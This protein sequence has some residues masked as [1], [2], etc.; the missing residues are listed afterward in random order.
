MPW[1][2]PEDGQEQ[3]GGDGCLLL[4]ILAIVFG[5]GGFLI[6]LGGI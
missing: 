1:R 3:G 6:T 2:P 5:V 4:A